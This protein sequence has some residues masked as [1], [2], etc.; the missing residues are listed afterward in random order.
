M[1]LQI[2]FIQPGRNSSLAPLHQAEVSMWIPSICLGDFDEKIKMP[3]EFVMT[4]DTTV[5]EIVNTLSF[6][7]HEK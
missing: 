4:G 7:G 3:K 5:H 6:P 2:N 1:N